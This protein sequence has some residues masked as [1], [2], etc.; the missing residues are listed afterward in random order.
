MLI[1]THS[2]ASTDAHQGSQ[3][4][5]PERAVRAGDGSR[6][7]RMGKQSGP[8]VLGPAELGQNLSLVIAETDL[9]WANQHP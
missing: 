9:G 2:A 6:L 8:S 4:E 3:A 5:P 7:R 1:P